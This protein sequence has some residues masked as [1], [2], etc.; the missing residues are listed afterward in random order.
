M[1]QSLVEVW[2][3]RSK[4]RTAEPQVRRLTIVT[5][6]T[7]TWPYA[8][9][10]LHLHYFHLVTHLLNNPDMSISQRREVRHKEYM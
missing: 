4:E 6:A 7:I 9:C 8:C 3:Y 1:T 5:P 2:L 10:W